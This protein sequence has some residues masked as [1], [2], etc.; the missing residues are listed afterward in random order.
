MTSEKFNKCLSISSNLKLGNRFAL[1][2]SSQEGELFVINMNNK[3]WLKH[4][5]SDQPWEIAK[6]AY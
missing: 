5:A 3:I 6:A 1:T 2:P 4:T